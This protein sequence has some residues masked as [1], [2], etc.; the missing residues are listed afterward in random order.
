MASKGEAETFV[1]RGDETVSNRSERA[2]LAI[3]ESIIGGDLA[4]G[5]HLV[6][7]DLAV[8]LG[9]SRQPIQQAMLLLKNDGLVVGTGS[10]GLKVAPL[11][12]T[13]TAWRY[14][15]RAALEEVAVQAVARKAAASSRFAD[16]LR[17]NGEALLE[18][19][20]KM[21]EARSP[22]GAVDADVAF[23]QFLCRESGNPLIDRTIEAHW[24][25]LRRTMIAVV[26]VENLGTSIWTE[27]QEIL[28]AIC[29]GRIEEAVA[30]AMAHLYRSEGLVARS[31]A[32]MNSGT[33]QDLGDQDLGE[34]DLGEPD[35]GETG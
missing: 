26:R 21:V 17:R 6:Q 16:K 33:P 22:R 25:Y 35:L 14:Q 3:K 28:R 18:H 31:L 34:P 2:Y 24:V 29:A 7:E 4:P 13:D 15:I 8:K 10:R 20:L 23:H 30:L 27:H 32:A 1:A 11:D 5:M 12:A 9:V 19:G